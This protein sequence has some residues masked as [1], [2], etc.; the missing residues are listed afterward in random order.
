MRAR[1]RGKRL[2]FVAIVLGII[3]IVLGAARLWTSGP[4]SVRIVVTR[5]DHTTFPATSTTIYDETLPDGALAQRLQREMAALSI[6]PPDPFAASMGC[7]GVGPHGISFT[8]ALTWSRNGMI[9]ETATNDGCGIWRE[10]GC[11]ARSATRPGTPDLV[12]D[13][14]TIVGT[15]P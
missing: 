8:Y 14:A 4:D 1:V 11:F 3:L 7:S 12:S 2:R 13:I 6:V 9:V 5:E 15:T 10:D